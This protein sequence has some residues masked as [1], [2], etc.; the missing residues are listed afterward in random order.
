[1]VD[2]SSLTWNP[3][4]AIAE[5]RQ[6][7]AKIMEGSSVLL[8]HLLAPCYSVSGG[9]ACAEDVSP[10]VHLVRASPAVAVVIASD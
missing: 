9:S 6:K 4:N 5:R 2:F 1:M 10:S 7:A 3:F 8:E